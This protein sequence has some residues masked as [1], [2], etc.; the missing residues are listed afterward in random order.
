VNENIKNITT[1]L[2]I[3]LV[4]GQTAPVYQGI[5]HANPD[6]VILIHSGDTLE[7]AERIKA[8]IVNEV[9]LVQFS[10]VNL[11]EIYSK[12]KEIKSNINKDT[13][14]SINVSSGTKP[15]SIVFYK[16]F[17]DRENTIVFYIDQNAVLWDLKTCK[18]SNVKFDM[19]A[20]FR[21]YGNPLT[22]FTDYN[23]FTEQDF[24]ILE[25]I[26][27]FRSFNFRDFNA[28]TFLFEDKPHLN[29]HILDSGSSL[30]WNKE[31]KQFILI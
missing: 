21:L 8:E 24:K 31:D 19:H 7:Q 9:E 10:P 17:I 4:G 12:L 29:K 27:E 3:S 20:Q 1:K 16:E 23:S 5:I 18:T 26:K 2:H 13:I 25:I 11:L 14:L 6:K 15:W 30:E 22:D 28:L